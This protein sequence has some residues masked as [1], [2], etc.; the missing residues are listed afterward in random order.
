M[1]RFSKKCNAEEKTS[2]QKSIDGILITT[3]TNLSK[4]FTVYYELVNDALSD[5]NIPLILV[6]K[7]FRSQIDAFDAF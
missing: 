3:Y 7:L 2:T 4:T 5:Q 1:L 6:I